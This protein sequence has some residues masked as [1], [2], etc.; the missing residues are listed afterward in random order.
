MTVTVAALSFK[1]P[2]KTF[3][4]RVKG[5][6]THEKKTEVESIILNMQKL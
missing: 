2:R 5:H 3:D 1:V 4:H 6:V